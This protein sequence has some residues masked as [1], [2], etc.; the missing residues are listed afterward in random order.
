ML[1]FLLG[2]SFSKIPVLCL[3]LRL[4]FSH[5]YHILKVYYHIK[6][7]LET[8]QKNCQNFYEIENFVRVIT[9]ML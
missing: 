7:F 5:I 2:K 8:S 1:L 3:N 4:S 9:R 6:N